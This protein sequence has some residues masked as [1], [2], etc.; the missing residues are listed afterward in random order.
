MSLWPPSHICVPSLTG[1]LG[2]PSSAAPRSGSRTAASPQEAFAKTG[3]S[4]PSIGRPRNEGSARCR[5][6]RCE[7]SVPAGGG[8][9][10]LVAPLPDSIRGRLQ[11]RRQSVGPRIPAEVLLD[12]APT[13]GGHGLG[14]GV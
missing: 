10:V 6:G 5:P 13:L 11:H 14:L 2:G 9:P 7:G 3:T 4:S 12:Q 8:P 1:T